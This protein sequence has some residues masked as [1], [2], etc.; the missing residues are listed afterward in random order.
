[1]AQKTTKPSRAYSEKNPLPLVG[2]FFL[3]ASASGGARRLALLGASPPPSAAALSGFPTPP[4][5]PSAYADG[6]K[7]KN[8][9]AT[10]GG[11]CA[12]AAAR[13]SSPVGA[14]A[15][16]GWSSSGGGGRSSGGGGAPFRANRRGKAEVSKDAKCERSEGGRSTILVVVGDD[17]ECDALPRRCLGDSAPVR[18]GPPAAAWGGCHR[19]RAVIGVAPIIPRLLGGG[20]V[21]GAAGEWGEVVG[22][23]LARV[24]QH[25]ADEEGVERRPAAAGRGA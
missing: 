13:G 17:A 19:Y 12:S 11:G 10:A 9:T 21:C 16:S 4:L 20:R 14:G 24:G 5:L 1:M 23:V 3:R 8:A 2:V 15:G 25:R 6:N 7:G 22:R 18:C